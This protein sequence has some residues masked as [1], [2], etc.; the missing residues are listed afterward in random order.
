MPT[1]WVKFSR[2]FS[3]GILICGLPG[4]FLVDFMVEKD[5]NISWF[6]WGV[7]IKILNATNKP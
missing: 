4:A 5:Q 6:A 7:V 1:L 2:I 3:G